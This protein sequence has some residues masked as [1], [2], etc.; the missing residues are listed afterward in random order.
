MER[1]ERPLDLH[2]LNQNARR[3]ADD[4]LPC[5]RLKSLRNSMQLADLMMTACGTRMEARPA[6]QAELEEIVNRQYGFSDSSS[7]WHEKPPF[8]EEDARDWG[9]Y[10]KDF[11]EYTNRPFE[12]KS[13]MLMRRISDEVLRVMDGAREW[14]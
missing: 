12:G 1:V 9:R 3:G 13:P 5:I 4:V 2:P 6:V 7:W 11:S 14:D 10:T 8:F